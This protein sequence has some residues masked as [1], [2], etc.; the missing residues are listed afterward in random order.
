M[1]SSG[2][3]AFQ[4]VGCDHCPKEPQF[5]VARAAYLYAGVADRMVKK[6]KYDRREEYAPELAKHM[7]AVVARDRDRLAADWI[8][9]V[10]LHHTRRRSRGFNQAEQIA[11][12]LARLTGMAL[13]RRVLRRTRPT[14]SQTFLGREERALNVAGAFAVRR[15]EGI[16]GSRVLLVDDVYTTGATLNECAR[17]L[18]EAGAREV[19]CLAFARA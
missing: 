6:L 12:A 8:V 13:A 2:N 16:A 19:V 10:P 3:A 11:R 17:V 18:R 4:P 14:E 15:P 9:P 1:C 7:A 5:S